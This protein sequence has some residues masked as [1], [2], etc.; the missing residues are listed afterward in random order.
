M[1]LAGLAYI[2]QGWVVGSEGFSAT[3]EFAID[4][5]DVLVFAWIIWLAVAAWRMKESFRPPTR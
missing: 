5:G 2:V 3:N 4:A 1:G